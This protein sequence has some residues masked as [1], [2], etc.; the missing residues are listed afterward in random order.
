MD[1]AT[2]TPVVPEALHAMRTAEALVGNPGGIHVEGVAA[3]ASLEASRESV[4]RELQC[5]PREIVF[6]SGLTES[7]TLAIVGS[8][9]ALE[10]TRRTLT[11]THW[12]VSAIEHSSVLACFAEVER[13]GGTVTHLDP[14]ARGVFTPEKVATALREDTVFVSIGWANNELGVVQPI[15]DIVHIIR[16]RNASIIVHT[17][18]G[19]AP[20]Y[21]KTGVNTLG[22]DLMS[23]GSNKLYGPHGIGA[24]VVKDSTRLAP[25]LMGGGQE[26]GLRPGTENVA[27]AAGFATALVS[28]ARDR[29]RESA[30]LCD[31]RDE[32][33]RTLIQKIPGL[34]VNGDPKR[35]LPHMLDISVPG[36][37]GEYLAL[38]LDARGIAVSTKSACREGEA[39]RSHVV[40]VLGGEEWRSL[41]TLRL[42]LG[43]QSRKTDIHSVVST[44][45]DILL[46]QKL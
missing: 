36:V 45:S 32:L 26:K 23:L 11:G 46:M 1:Y 30:R 31:I 7:N 35:A 33:L 37:S 8:A 10:R 17:D 41:N 24:L 34:V 40:A 6:A 39:N 19:Q 5:K 29:E 20:L 18:A 22:V 25:V 28:V 42:S 14:D 27:L 44:I 4:A 21:L 9:R 12:I 2:A 15:R 38:A 43:R 16:E 3:L 13:L